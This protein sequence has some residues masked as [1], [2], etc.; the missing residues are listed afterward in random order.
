[1]RYRATPDFWYCYR[2]LP[3]E[4]QE[5]A[6]RCYELL[7]QDSRYPLLH[8]KKVGQFWSV[9]IGLHYRAL[10]LEEGDDIAWFWI[11]THAEYDQL[12]RG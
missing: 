4:I 8:F 1:M 12:L 2:Q 11:G 9:R 6:D 7:K 10:A 3:E 5:L